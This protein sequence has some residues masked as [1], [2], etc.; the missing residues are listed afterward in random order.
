VAD[1]PEGEVG[2]RSSQ[3]GGYQVQVQDGKKKALSPEAGQARLSQL[4][5]RMETEKLRVIRYLD[6]KKEGK[7]ELEI[8]VPDGWMDW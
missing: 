7:K 2:E 1:P 5:T 4:R 8:L 3:E 6:N